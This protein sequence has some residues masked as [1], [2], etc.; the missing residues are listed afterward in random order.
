MVAI[1]HASGDSSG[2]A[3][4]T[5]VPTALTIPFTFGYSAAKRLSHTEISLSVQSP[6]R[7]YCCLLLAFLNQKGGVGKSPLST[8]AADH[9]CRQGGK[10]PL[11]DADPQGAASDWAGLRDDQP[12]P[13]MQI[14][15]SNM[16]G[17]ILSY[18]GNYSHVVIDGPP[19][20]EDLSRAVIVAS[21]LVVVSVEAS[22]ASDWASQAM[23]RQVQEARQYRGTVRRRVRPKEDRSPVGGY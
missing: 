21:D 22:G 8:N 20:A 6:A 17:D 5:V 14:V 4:L 10:V 1:H 9:L 15:R 23:V 3:Q 19:R 13:V 7:V 11:I 18:A 16:A 2:Q 12:F